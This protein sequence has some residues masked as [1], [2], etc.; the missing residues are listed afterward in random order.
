MHKE[1]GRVAKNIS[2]LYV[3]DEKDTREQY[4]HIFELLFKEVKS[5][6]NGVEAL[7]EYNR[8]KYDLV[9]TDLTM[10]KM[11]GVDMIGEM[12]K[13]K[14]EQH[15]VIMTAHNTSE[16]LRNS[17]EFQVDGI[18]L[19][20]VAMDKLFQLLYKVCHLIDVDKKELNNE[21]LA[22]HNIND[23]IEDTNQ[24]LFL[25]VVDRFD[26]IIKHF[27][28]ETHK[29]IIE[30]VKEHMSNFGV[31]EENILELHEDVIICGVDKHYIDNILEAVQAFSSNHN[32][33]IVWFSKVKIYITLSYG[34]VLLKQQS[35]LKNL[36]DEFLRHVNSIISNIKSDEHSDLVVR[37][38]V[39]IEEAKKNNALTWLGV[40]L[41]ALKQDTILPFYQP[42]VDIN[43]MQTVAY[44]VFARIK[45]DDKYILP[46]F[47]IDLSQKAG[48]LEDISQSIFKQ[49]FARLSETEYSFHI[50]LTD[51]EWRNTAIKD[52]L[53]YLSKQYKIDYNRI[54]LDI[55]DYDTLKPDSNVL[56]SLLELKKLGCKIALK[57][58]ASANINIELLSLLQPDYIKVNQLLLQK[59][60]NDKNIEKALKFLIDYVHNV[61]IKS[62][63]VGVESEELLEE[64]KKLGIDYAQGY[65]IK[66]P[67]DEL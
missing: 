16:N 56:K 36:N 12:L 3:E 24:A 37:M 39:D 52:Y 5:V 32:S 35:S 23:M 54:I 4:E 41:D 22:E 27:G 15:I 66:E 2:L 48:I 51:A 63:L 50:N 20:P 58:F 53:V 61:N 55:M 29:Y 59:S 19:K 26:D 57:G 17:I 40:T 47:F 65:F 13:I 31:E 25:V 6:E 21:N 18:L 42:V 38:D 14:P 64:G 45:Q 9:I 60:L 11:N 28:Y 43:T 62:I 10:P 49:S 30:T 33:L 8:K 46:E 34:I 44:E 7:E 67:S 1:L